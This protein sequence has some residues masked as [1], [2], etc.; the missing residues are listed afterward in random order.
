MNI[1]LSRT[2]TKMTSP[3]YKEALRALN[4]LQ[5]NAEAIAKWEQERKQ[6]LELDI[7]KEMDQCF[8]RVNL[9]VHFDNT[10][11]LILKS[12]TIFL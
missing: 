6:N 10:I 12:S 5:T 3:S 1:L 7:K 8:E 4:S 2:F 9:N 11:I